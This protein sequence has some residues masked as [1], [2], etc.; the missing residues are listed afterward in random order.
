[1]RRETFETPGALRLEVRVPS[2]RIDLESVEGDE[3]T[4]ELEGSPEIEE[5]ARIEV[6]QRRDGHEVI[7]VI[8]D[9]GLFRRFRGDVRVRVSAPPGADVEVS[10]ASADVDGRGEFGA[11]EVNTASGDVA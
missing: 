2:G 5:D 3:T 4:I 10:T 7:V 11:L 9:R 8:E 6:R 1:M